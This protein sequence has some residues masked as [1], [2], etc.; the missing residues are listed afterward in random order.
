M[1]SWWNW[2]NRSSSSNLHKTDT[3]QMP[4]MPLWAG[5]YQLAKGSLMES[6]SPVFVENLMSSVAS[7]PLGEQRMAAVR[8]DL[9][10]IAE[11]TG[12]PQLDTMAEF[13]VAVA[14]IN[15]LK[16]QFP[17]FSQQR[18]APN[19]KAWTAAA[20]ANPKPT[21]KPDA[22]PPARL[23][24]TG[25]SSY[26]WQYLNSASQPDERPGD[27]LYLNGI[28]NPLRSIGSGRGTYILM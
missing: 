4:K 7:L 24:E 26:I 19:A 13:D 12:G 9:Y 23:F 16:S 18:F 21:A 17:E 10:A 8:N 20:A 22:E 25:P 5:H 2:R 15:N 11:R 6:L 14:Y 1:R 27:P 3:C 28:Y